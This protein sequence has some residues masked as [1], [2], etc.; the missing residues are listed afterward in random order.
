VETMAEGLVSPVPDSP[1][2]LLDHVVAR[3]QG[4]LR[5][6]HGSASSTWATQVYRQRDCVS[7]SA[8]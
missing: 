4:H 5:C 1:A 8:A 2:A 6:V 7:R 3:G